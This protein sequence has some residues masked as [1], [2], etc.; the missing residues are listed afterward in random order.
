MEQVEVNEKKVKSKKPLVIVGVIVLVLIAFGVYYWQ[1]SLMYLKTD[2]SR[3]SGSIVSISTKVPGRLKEVRV[4]E[5]DLVKVGQVIAVLSSQEI[6]EQVKQAKAGVSEADAKLDAVENG[7]RT[8]EI[9]MAEAQAQ[10]AMVNMENARKNYLRYQALSSQGAVSQQSLDSAKTAYDVAKSQ[11]NV[12]REQANLLHN[13]S[14]VEDINANKANLE[15]AKALLEYNKTNLQETVVTSPVE[16]IV[17]QKSANPGEVISPG[18]T[19]VNVVNT[20]DLWLNARIEETKIGNL[21]IGQPVNFTLDAYKGVK[22]HGQ[23]KEI[24]AATSSVF[25]LFSSENSSGNFTKVTQR[26]PIKITLPTDSNYLF[27]PG[28][29]ALI[30]IKVK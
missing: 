7:P 18:Q 24:G 13:G 5:G 12:A 11:Y 1:M 29:S 23:I 4:K 8:Q 27:R 14:R 30:E 10:A 20:N 17:A 6:E 2:D 16:G 26:I 15:K 22:F 25:A 9:R 3:I 21:K 19:I 28:M